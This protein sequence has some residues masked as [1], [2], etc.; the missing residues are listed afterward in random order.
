ML[1]FTVEV[2]INKPRDRVVASMHPDNLP[3]WF[4]GFIEMKHLS[5]PL[6]E[7]GSKYEL[8]FRVGHVM[9][10]VIETFIARQMPESFSCT[11]EEKNSLQLSE[12]WL[13]VLPNNQT[14][15]ISTQS[16]DGAN[17]YTKLMMKLMPWVFKAHAK[18]HMTHFKDFAESH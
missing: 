10:K 5:G 4:P 1:N 14:R 8:N 7:Q 15:W 13:E 3:E 9:C 18:R 12:N 2:D 17:W 6:W 16:I 11:F